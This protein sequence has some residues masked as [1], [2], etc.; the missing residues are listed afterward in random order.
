MATTLHDGGNAATPPDAADMPTG[1]MHSLAADLRAPTISRA[2]QCQCGRPVFLGNSQCLA[3]GTPLGYVT[4][5]LGV[6]PL[7]PATHDNAE[8][9]TFT[10]FG[11]D[12]G[13]AIAWGTAIFGQANLPFSRRLCA[14]TNPV[15][16]QTR[17]FSL[18]AR[19]ERNTKIAPQNGSSFSVS[20]TTAASP[21]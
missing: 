11:H 9:E 2:Y 20:C 15:P 5:R 14:R 17:S 8:P 10:V 21:S 7:A 16:S 3:C 18:S 6:V 19:F 12:W 1:E 13:G 4:E